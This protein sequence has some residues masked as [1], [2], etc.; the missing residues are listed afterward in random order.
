MVYHSVSWIISLARFVLFWALKISGFSTTFLS[1][2]LHVLHVRTC[3]Q[4]I[5]KTIH[6]LRYFPILW[7]TEWCLCF[8]F[9]TGIKTAFLTHLHFA[10]LFSESILLFHDFPGFPWPVRTLHQTWQ[11]QRRMGHFMVSATIFVQGEE[12]IENNHKYMEFCRL[13]NPRKIFT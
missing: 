3:P 5:V 9:F 7:C 2:L 10:F 11:S 8:L 6:Y 4:C 12:H 1:F 13:W